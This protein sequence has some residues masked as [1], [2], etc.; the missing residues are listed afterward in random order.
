MSTVGTHTMNILL[1]RD[2]IHRSQGQNFSIVTKYI[3][4]Y[5]FVTGK[6]MERTLLEIKIF[7]SG[8]NN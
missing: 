5:F 8:K 6:G 2:C 1:S 4:I 7:S 3:Y